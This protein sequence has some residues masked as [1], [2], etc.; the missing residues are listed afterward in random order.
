MPELHIL[1]SPSAQ[2]KA[3]RC[4]LLYQLQYLDRWEPREAERSL[5]ARL[6][7]N[8][9][10][11]ACEIVHKA[12]MGGDKALL[13][14]TAFVM[15]VV[16]EAIGLFDRQF[17]YCVEQGIVFIP[18]VD[19]LSRTELRRVIPL[20]AHHT[21]VLQWQ[22][23]LGVEY[24]IKEDH[25]RPDIVGLNALGFHTVGD[26]KYKSSLLA[27]YESNTIEEFHW[28]PQFMQYNKAWRD[29][30]QLGPDVPVYSTLLLTI[31][32][33]FKIKPVEWLYTPEQL[34]LWYQGAV[35]ISTTIRG[36]K[37]GTVLP[38]SATTHKDNFGW[39]PMKKG[40]LEFNL[41]PELMKTHYVQLNEL[42]E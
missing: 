34:Q 23:V 25:C 40:C 15:A 36:I 20:Y 32:F 17:N 30:Q 13:L 22:K 2:K 31:G 18:S 41:D 28:D 35:D 37:A 19:S 38:R 29:D 33:P 11:K 16:D 26:C 10:A 1:E 24:S 21:P 5:P 3:D 12:I 14:E 4:R 39:C 42:P 6:R 8:A 9:F 27:K 7:G